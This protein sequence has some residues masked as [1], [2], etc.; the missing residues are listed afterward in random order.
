MQGE[1]PSAGRRA[2]FVRLGGC[3]LACGWC[4][5][6]YTWDGNRFDLRA[7]LARQPVEAIVDRALAGSPE[8]VVISGGEPLLHQLQPAWTRMLTMLRAAG[9]DI[10]VE[11]N[12]TIVP[13]AATL[14]PDLAVR[15][16]VS[17]KLAHS[18][19]PAARRIRPD[20]LAAFVASGRANFKFVCAT[21]DDVDEAAELADRYHLDAPVWISPEGTTVE[22]VLIHTKLIADRVIERGFN[23]GTRLHVLAWGNERGR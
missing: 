3:N 6:P 11:T 19:D 20:V 22:A 5:T 1:G 15:F 12:G 13:T 18:G 21:P 7:E 16:N 2:S 9:A 4:D 14:E 10:E 17:P 8:L 23:L